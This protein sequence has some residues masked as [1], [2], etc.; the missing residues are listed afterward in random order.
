MDLLLPATKRK[1]LI[2]FLAGFCRTLL[3]QVAAK[4][5]LANLQMGEWPFYLVTGIPSA[6]LSEAVAHNQYGSFSREAQKG[7]PDN[8]PE[9]F[10]AAFESAAAA[11]AWD[12]LQYGHLVWTLATTNLRSGLWTIRLRRI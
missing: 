4:Q 5:T 8:G 12:P 3:E 9:A 11:M 10:S 6:A 1:H 2:L 7:T